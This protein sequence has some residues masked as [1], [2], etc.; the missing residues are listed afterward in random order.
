MI[1]AACKIEFIPEGG[2]AITLVDA[3]EWMES[4]PRFSARQDL[5]EPDGIGKSDGYI[6][7]LGG[8]SVAVTFAVAIEPATAAEMFGA[9]LTAVPS[10]GTGALIMTGGGEVTTFEPAVDV[11]AVPLLP[12]PDGVVIRRFEFTTAL[13]TTETE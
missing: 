1:S 13:P 6:K 8:V 4:L 3:G 9:F 12:G 5:F 11:S 7:P 2:A 10:L